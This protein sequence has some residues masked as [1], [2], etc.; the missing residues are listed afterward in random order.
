VSTQRYIEEMI[1][2][3]LAELVAGEAESEGI[4]AL[5]ER[6]GRRTFEF[7]DEPGLRWQVE[8]RPKGSS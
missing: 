3:W 4:D 1:R 2:D 5:I 7:T 6:T 8:V